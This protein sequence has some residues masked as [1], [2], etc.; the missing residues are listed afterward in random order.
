MQKSLEVVKTENEMQEFN[1]AR[2]TVKNK[3][4][5][6]SNFPILKRTWKC[7]GSSF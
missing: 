6:T 5:V 2:K 4:S 3:N 1:R 7:K